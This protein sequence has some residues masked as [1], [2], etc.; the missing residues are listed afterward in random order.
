[1]PNNFFNFFKADESQND[2][3]RLVILNVEDIIPNRYQPRKV[4]QEDKIKEL[5]Q[6]IDKNGLLQPIVVR[7]YEPHKYEI[8][9]GERRFRAVQWL[10]RKTIQAIVRGFDNT[11]SAIQALNEN[12]QRENLSSIEEAKAYKDLLDLTNGTQESL[13]HQLGK[14]QSAVANKLRLL[15]LDEKIQTAIADGKLSERHGREMLRLE[16]DDQ[17]EVLQK[18]TEENLNVT[19]TKKL[20]D[21]YLK[22]PKEIVK[23]KT[24]KSKPKKQAKPRANILT[25]MDSLTLAT[26]TLKKSLNAIEKSGIAVTQELK[27]IDQDNVEMVIRLKKEISESEIK[28]DNGDNN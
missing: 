4:F 2:E 18:I 7:E 23:K 22:P 1:M 3:G 26:Q 6:S 10:Q 25:K 14:S 20:I 12:L 5:A 21:K 11:A 19:Q 15:K 16:H 8:V 13:A 28:E 24:A 17:M 27:Q 9:A